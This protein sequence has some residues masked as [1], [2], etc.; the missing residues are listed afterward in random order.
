MKKIMIL[1]LSLMFLVTLSGLAL[2][3]SMDSPG[4]PSGGS[5]MHTLDQIYTYLNSGTKGAMPGSFQEPSE[6]PGPTMKTLEETYQDIMAKFDQCVTTTAA[7][8]KS[9]KPFFCTQPGS[10]GV[11]TGAAQLV[12]TPTQTPTPTITPTPTQTPTSTPACANDAHGLSLP[13]AESQPASPYGVKF[14]TNTA[15]VLDKVYIH[16]SAI[17]YADW[18][19]LYN[20]SFQGITTSTT[21]GSDGNGNYFSFDQNLTNNTDYYIGIGATGNFNNY[22]IT[23]SFPYNRTNVNFIGGLAS[24]G[25][26]D[27]PCDSPLIFNVISIHTCK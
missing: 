7:D 6:M 14:H 24:S 9:G 10:W 20:S 13:F 2:A 3:G 21:K 1:V 5:G 23:G 25:G 26:D 11:Q 22:K 8:V 4:L 16:S 27:N 19:I 18:C 15:A 12:P 17:E